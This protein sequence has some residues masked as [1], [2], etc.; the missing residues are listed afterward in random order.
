MAVDE[1]NAYLDTL[2]TKPEVRELSVDYLR[3]V[4]PYTVNVV[5]RPGGSTVT[6]VRDDLE[7]DSVRAQRYTLEVGLGSKGLFLGSARIDYRCQT[8]RGHQ[9]FSPELCL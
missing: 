5:S 8:G 9:D 4:E 6:V 3:P 7:D 1:F 2:T